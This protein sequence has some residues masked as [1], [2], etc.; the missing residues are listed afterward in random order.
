M[1]RK[2]CTATIQVIS[3]ITCMMVKL[4]R[5]NSYKAMVMC[6]FVLKRGNSTI[7]PLLFLDR[8]PGCCLMRLDR[9]FVVLFEMFKHL[10]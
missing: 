2:F 8:E 9:A 4:Q 10:K 7:L 6:D 5:L 3:K 1:I